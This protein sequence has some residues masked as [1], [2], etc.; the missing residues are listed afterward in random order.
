MILASSYP[1]LNLLWTMLIFFALVCWIWI[2]ITVFVD[3]FRRHDTSGWAKVFWI[4]LI[5]ILPFLGVF[6]YLIAENEGMAERAAE[7]ST[8]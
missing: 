3:I 4:I 2:V 8:R 6:I 5:I 7:R 1:F